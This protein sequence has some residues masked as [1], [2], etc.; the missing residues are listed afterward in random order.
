MLAAHRSARR[1]SAICAL[2]FTFNPIDVD[3]RSSPADVSHVVV[4]AAAGAALLLSPSAAVGAAFGSRCLAE[5]HSAGGGWR[6]CRPPL[7]RRSFAVALSRRYARAPFPIP[8]FLSS[9]GVVSRPPDRSLVTGLAAPE[10]PSWPAVRER[11]LP[12]FYFY[13]TSSWELAAAARPPRSLFSCVTAALLSS[14]KTPA[15][16]WPTPGSVNE[17]FCLLF[18]RSI[19]DRLL[20]WIRCCAA[21]AANAAAPTRRLLHERRLIAVTCSL[22]PSLARSQTDRQRGG[23]DRFCSD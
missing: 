14:R 13:H 18:V 16:I 8:N 10:R 19:V 17:R 12:Y 7:R 23:Y 3:L 5:P 20:N 11:R 21:S 4:A 6:R 9:R 15:S 1:L 2:A 22:H